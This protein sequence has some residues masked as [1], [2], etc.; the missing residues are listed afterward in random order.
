ME[1]AVHGARIKRLRRY[2]PKFAVCLCLMTA[3]SL[4]FATPAFA[5]GLDDIGKMILETLVDV[6]SGGAKACLDFYIDLVTTAGQQSFLSGSFE[7]LF[8]STWASDGSSV[9]GIIKA[10]HSTLLV[11][12]GE[13]ILA[14]VMLVQVVKISGRIDATATLPAVKEIVFL[15]V[16]YVLLHWLITDSIDILAAAYNEFN[17]ITTEL[18][19]RVAPEVSSIMIPDLG[20]NVGAALLLFLC[21]IL[22]VLAGMLGNIIAWVV[23]AVRAIQLYIYT[24]FSPIPLSLLGFEETRSMGINFLKN[25]CA[26][27]L[28]GAVL[29]FIITIYPLICTHVVAQSADIYV[30][31]ETGM[32]LSPGPL[33]SLIGL[34]LLFIFVILKSGS[35]A[36]DIFGG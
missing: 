22:M 11:P 27:C 30:S 29:A 16:I 3:T 10:V 31:T 34:P 8:G 18:L 26:L 23:S 5:W 15:A 21:S 25:F 32:E 2:A 12:L 17:K 28:A 4:V 6:I 35:A 20:D 1:T 7:T 36:R 14:L 24:A 33:C 19:N 13:S 9:W